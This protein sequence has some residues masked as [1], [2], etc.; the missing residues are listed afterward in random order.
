VK[1]ALVVF[2]GVAMVFGLDRVFHGH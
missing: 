2:V 1:M